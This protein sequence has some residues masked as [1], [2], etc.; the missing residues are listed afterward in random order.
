MNPLEFDLGLMVWTLI[1]FACLLVVLSRFAFKPLNKLL[2]QREEHIRQ[3]VEQA[4]AARQEA[5]KTLELNE[6]QLESARDE[7]RRIVNEGHKIVSRMKRESQEQARREAGTLVAQAR[8]SINREAQKSLED[9]K[10]SVVTLS[11]RIARQVI[12]ENLD[13]ERHKQLTDDFIERLKKTH[14]QRKQ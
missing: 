14:A 11:V 4:E 13:E 6:Q 3:S 1:T 7:A 12:R 2:R 8:A 5:R 10:S 9:L